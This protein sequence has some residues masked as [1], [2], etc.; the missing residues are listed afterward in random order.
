MKLA[1]KLVKK[2]Q[3]VTNQCLF[4]YFLTDST[5]VYG[6]VDYGFEF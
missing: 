3:F 6:A 5:P 1:A 4:I 2:I